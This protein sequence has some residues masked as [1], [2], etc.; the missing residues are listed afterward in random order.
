MDQDSRD[1]D[2]LSKTEIIKSLLVQN[3]MRFLLKIV[4][5]V[6]LNAAIF[7]V[8]D[9][10]IFPQELNITGGIPAYAFI[11]LVFAL[12]NIVIKPII[13]IITLPFRIL[14]FGLLGFIINA[15][16]LLI[17]KHSVNF[18]EMFSA[19]LDISGWTTY[20]LAGV[21]LAVFNSLLNMLRS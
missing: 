2:F 20:L 21:I 15:F 8:L 7:W 4:L 13:K 19:S 17:L 6:V 10:K 18:L 1:F 5:V 9:E 14:S 3:I 16:M 11:A 12:L